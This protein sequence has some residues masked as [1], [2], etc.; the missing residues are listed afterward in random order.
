MIVLASIVPEVLYVK[1]TVSFPYA[2]MSTPH[3]SLHQ[4]SLLSAPNAQPNESSI[5]SIITPRYQISG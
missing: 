5:Y 2:T 4:L 3:T 1:H